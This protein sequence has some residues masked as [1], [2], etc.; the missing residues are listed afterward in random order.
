MIHT[1]SYQKEVPIASPLNAYMKK[2]I[3][4]IKQKLR[5]THDFAISVKVNGQLETTAGLSTEVGKEIFFTMMK[6]KV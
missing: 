5:D 1:N 2:T 3:A 4:S 6:E